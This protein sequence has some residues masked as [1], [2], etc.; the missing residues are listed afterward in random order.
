MSPPE[1]AEEPRR[2]AVLLRAALALASEHDLEQ[3]LGRIV[4]NAAEVAG[5]RYAAL[6]IYDAEGQIRRFVHHG[7]DEATV[8]DIGPLPRGRGLLGEAIVAAGPV[9]SEDISADPR[10]VGF[11]P[12][13]PP[14]RT[15]LGVPVVGGGRR[16]GNL[17]LTDKVDGLGFSEED[18]H[19]VVAL[20]AF[21]AA[22]VESAELVAV[23]RERA[24][25]VAELTA[26]RERERASADLMARV[27]DAQE[28][29]RARVARDLHD[30]IGQALT[31]VLLGLR[32]VE[33][34][35]SAGGA[36][37]AVRE[38]LEEVRTLVA[39][40]LGSVRHLAFDLRPTVLDDVGLV[41]ALERLVAETATRHGLVACLDLD[42]LDADR[43]LAPA[44][45][46]V[47][48]RIVQEALTNVA[49][50]AA[51]TAV[52]VRVA[53]DTAAVRG[54][55]TD[56]GKGFEPAPV[57]SSLGLAGMRERA[58]LAGGR[59]EVVSAPGAGTRVTFEV[60]LG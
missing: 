37:E 6:G 28:A 24:T 47:V 34:V 21:A 18:E 4:A 27:I 48:Y 42:G 10:A 23:E 33:G 3:V 25:A 58:A 16:W 59:L 46:T 60:P 45:E 38:R 2:T 12:N 8:A 5:A 43:R 30:D 50:H 15:F 26:A 41:A 29:E 17:Y 31:S 9:R 39:D 54:E 36:P 14:M 19:L 32:L 57:A 49:R 40:A 56:D 1:R 7:L 11:P 13:H 35:V 44:L 52:E 55:V 22:A 51:A 20:A 53:A